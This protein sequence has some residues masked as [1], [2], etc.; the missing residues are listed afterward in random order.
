M[1]GMKKKFFLG[2]ILLGI[3]LI[4][5]MRNN[6]YASQK[7]NQDNFTSLKEND[8]S[9]LIFYK[10][11][12][13]YCAGAEKEVLEQSR[14]S[15]VPT[16]FIDAESASGKP[17]VKKYH[18][19]YAA[20]VITIRGGKVQKYIYAEKQNDTYRAKDDVINKVFGG[21]R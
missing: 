19:R 3:C 6:D 7:N 14:K 11:D 15:N 13:P 10:K 4:I 2:V 8:N 5:A 18:V 1:I 21:E 9:N 20:T 16:F 17:L 12:C